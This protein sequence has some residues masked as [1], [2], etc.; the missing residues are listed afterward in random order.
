[1]DDLLDLPQHQHD[2]RLDGIE[3]TGQLIVA[4]IT[5]RVAAILMLTQAG[6][7]VRLQGS[8]Q[9]IH[10]IVLHAVELV[11]DKGDDVKIAI[12]VRPA[13]ELE[14]LRSEDAARMVAHTLPTESQDGQNADQPIVHFFQVEQIVRP[15]LDLAGL[16]RLRQLLEQREAIPTRSA[17]FRAL[18]KG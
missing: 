2:R 12:G 8:Q 5:A 15:L 1:M 9:R 4:L 16:G 6:V 11:G 10:Q 18:I 17:G 7:L 3:Q 13:G 14:D